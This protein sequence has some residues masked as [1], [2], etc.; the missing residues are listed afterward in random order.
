MD[1]VQE[2]ATFRDKHVNNI[3]EIERQYH[4]TS[5]L[6]QKSAA[7]CKALFQEYGT[8]CDKSNKLDIIRVF[9]DRGYY[10]KMKTLIA[11]SQSY[12]EIKEILNAY[13][14][15]I[16]LFNNMSELEEGKYIKL[17]DMAITCI[18]KRIEYK[19]SCVD[20]DKRDANHDKAVLHQVFHLKKNNEL[21]RILMDLRQ[22]SNQLREVAHEKALLF[23]K[24]QAWAREVQLKHNDIERR[25]KQEDERRKQEDERRKQ[26]DERRQHEDRLVTA[27]K[28]QVEKI[29]NAEK[30]LAKEYKLAEKVQ[31]KLDYSLFEAFMMDEIAKI[32]VSPLET[33]SEP[34]DI[35]LDPQQLQASTPSVHKRRYVLTSKHELQ[36]GL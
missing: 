9:F 27:E 6:K 35:D 19:Y 15:Y 5:N 20:P 31:D 30:D 8:T 18:K 4:N 24:K 12:Q 29:L 2:R 22:R 1:F 34:H 16:W 36:D 23:K 28:A 10:Q 33:S 32:E 3:R 11:E 25:R 26:E 7:E 13:R 14:L 21:K 17:E